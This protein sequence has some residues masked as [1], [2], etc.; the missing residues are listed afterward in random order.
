MAES[1]GEIPTPQANE[2]KSQQPRAEIKLDF[3][4]NSLHFTEP[5][6]YADYYRGK[7]NSLG[8]ID[9]W[10]NGEE[11]K[12]QIVAVAKELKDNPGTLLKFDLRV[13]SIGSRSFDGADDGLQGYSEVLVEAA[14]EQGYNLIVVADYNGRKGEYGR[15]RV[16]KVPVDQ[17]KHTKYLLIQEQQDGAAISAYRGGRSDLTGFRMEA[18]LVDTNPLESQK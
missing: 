3:I 4:P 10:E 8:S 13:G 16:E 5:G 11:R 15:T 18:K 6:K 14:H 2:I 17:D 12:A 1:G 9:P 7:V